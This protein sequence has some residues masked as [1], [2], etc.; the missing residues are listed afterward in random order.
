[1]DGGIPDAQLK[2]AAPARRLDGYVRM[3]RPL[4]WA[5]NGL[6]IVPL[7]TSHQVTPGALASVVLAM[8]A[9]SLAASSA[10]VLNDLVD[11]SADRGHPFKRW[12]PLVSGEVP[13]SHGLVI[14][15]L[16]LTA[17]VAVVLL[18]PW[19]V[20]VALAAYAATNLAYSLV[21]KRKMLVDVLTLAGLYTLRVV[22][23]AAAIGVS[24]SQWLLVF[25]MF[26]FL[27]LA[28]VKRHAELVL[29]IAGGLPDP[30]NR[31]YRVADLPVLVALAAA[32]GCAAVVVLA[33]YIAGPEQLLL[34]RH[35]CWLY[36]IC[37]LLLYWFAR[38]LMRSNRGELPDDPVVF[39]LKDPVS[40]GAAALAVAVVAVAAYV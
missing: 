39:A 37:P 35:R 9:F 22:A 16:L 40:L 4:Q 24:V 13:V 27:A 29:R 32:A 12:R 10:Y 30:A 26:I 19:G 25:S 18:L 7:I 14:A 1:M 6:L 17:A 34:Y 2:A 15:P 36:L 20:G 11:L 38:V 28:L 21:L 3:L 33:L 8:A 31:D 5:K 23:G